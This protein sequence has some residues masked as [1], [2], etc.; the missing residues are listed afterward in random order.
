MHQDPIPAIHHHLFSNF[1]ITGFI[2]IPEVPPS[3]PK[4]KEKR[5][6]NEENQFGFE[7][8]GLSV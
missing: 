6:E 1:R 2:W 8:L 7:A 3:Y 4:E 5:A